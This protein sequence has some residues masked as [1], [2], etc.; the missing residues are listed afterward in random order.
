MLLAIVLAFL[1]VQAAIYVST[2]LAEATN[3]PAS[4]FKTRGGTRPTHLIVTALWPIFGALG[5]YS[6]E[7]V[8][9]VILRM[10]DLIFGDRSD[11]PTA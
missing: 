5:L 10:D 11:W 6:Y 2:D 9:F 8:K 3:Y 7:T 4:T 1:Y